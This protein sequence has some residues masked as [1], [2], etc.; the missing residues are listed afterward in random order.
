MIAKKTGVMCV[1]V[2]LLVSVIG[3]SVGITGGG[4]IEEESGA[5]DFMGDVVEIYTW[6]DLHN[7]HF[8]LDGN[9]RLMNDLG[10][11]D[12]GYDDYNKGAGWWPVG[13]GP[14]GAPEY[15]F[16]GSFDGRNHNITGLYIDHP[17]P[18]FIGL[19][20]YVGE[21]GEVRNVGLVDVDVSGEWAVGGLVGWNHG[22]VSNSYATGNVSGTGLYV[23]G[24]VGGNDWGGTVSN[25]YATGNVKGEEDVGGLVGA[26]VGT[27]SNSYATGNVSGDEAVG[28][29]VGANV[30]TFSNSYATG[31][32]SGDE[33]VGGLVGMNFGMVEDS[34]ATGNVNGDLY[35]GGLVGFNDYG[36]VLNSYATGNVSGNWTVGGLVGI[37]LE[38]T[39]SNSYATGDVSGDRAVGGLV[40]ENWGTVENSFWDIETSGTTE[41]DGGIGINTTEMLTQSTFTDAG[42]DFDG[43]WHMV[44]NITYPLFQWQ[45]LLGESYVELYLQAYVESDRW[46]FVSFNLAT[47]DTSLPSLLQD[48]GG[49]YDRVMWYDA[50]QGEWLTYVPGRPDHYNNLRI[51]DHT[52]GLWIR[53][54]E[55]ITLSVEGYAPSNTDI[56]LYPGW[57]MVGL[58]SE[59]AGT[60]QAHGLPAEVTRI[61]YF[62]ASDEY[63]IAYPDDVAGFV[64]E[65]GQGYW[66]YNGAD[67]TVTWTVEY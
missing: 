27:F 2:L 47:V 41:S 63:N 43:V 4:T 6:E 19:F 50:S 28:G 64:F 65:P 58:P 13:E 8:D 45:E 1:V 52:M 56:K 48:I 59:T 39:V 9:Y 22:T 26:N 23:G 11:E 10:P 29:L 30:G 18:N 57:N 40:G 36:T 53:M 31:N 15:H 60:G 54:T 12:E 14:W 62:D 66:V 21:E 7:M 51:W 25:S 24:L 49:D 44:E 17:R 67:E 20:G 46:N 16:T 33:A 35:V 32:V 55:N 61:G 3:V 5:T 38:S 37:N 34:Y 42:W